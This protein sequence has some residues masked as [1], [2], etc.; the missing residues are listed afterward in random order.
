MAKRPTLQELQ[1][2]IKVLEARL[3]ERAPLDNAIVSPTDGS[4]TETILDALVEHVI[5]QD[6]DLKIQWANRAACES[7]GL[8]RKDLIGRYCYEIWPQRSE[9]CPDCPVLEAI[10]SGQPA[11]LEKQTPDGRT[12]LIQGQAVRNAAGTIIGGIETTLDITAQKAVETALRRSEERLQTITQNI[13]EVF[14]L[15][16]VKKQRVVYVSPAYEEIWGRTTARLLERYEEWQESIHPEDLAYAESSFASILE[17]GGGE[18][19]EYRIVR[20]D[21]SVRWVSDRGF[22]IR[23]PDGQISQ[24]TGFAEDI[25]DRKA[26]EATLQ[27]INYIISQ[28]PIVAFLWQNKPGWPVQFVTDNVSALLGYPASQFMSGKK[29]YRDVIHPADL[30]RVLREVQNFSAE[31]DRL[32]FAHQPYRIVTQQGEIRWVQDRTFIRRD[33]HGRI[34]HYQ[35]LVEDVTQRKTAEDALRASEANYRRLFSVGPDAIIL[36]D[37][38]TKQVIDANP[39]AVKQYGYTHA[40]L[41]GMKAL[42]LSAEPEASAAHISQVSTQLNQDAPSTLTHRLH[43][44]KD[45]TVFPVEIASGFYEHQGRRLICAILRDLSA[46]EAAEALVKETRLQVEAILN[47][48]PDLAW[49]KDAHSRFIA[50]NE[51]FG[52][53]CGLPADQLPGK[54]DLDIWPP[55]LAQRYRADDQDVLQSAQ[56]KRVEE[57]LVDSQGQT[58]WIETIKSPLFNPQGDVIGT[59]GIARDITDQKTARE[60]LQAEK[61]RLAVTLRSIGDAVIT[62]DR[63]GTITL[64]NPLAESLTGWTEQHAV[65]QPI[66]TVFHIINEFTRERCEDPVAKVIAGEQTVGLANNTL[67]VRRDG[68][69]IVIA[70]SGAPNRRNDGRIIG[71]VLVFRDITEQRRLQNELAKVQKI[72]SLGVEKG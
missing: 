26:M 5:Y 38:E 57:P 72:E 27:D 31:S 37:M 53:A 47:N 22:A 3:A 11:R 23:G 69:E 56:G 40:E 9:V 32:E 65:G 43:K 24:I 36:V 50:V 29:Q 61:E 14:W 66:R 17:T 44:K 20:P 39:A 6:R 49:L 55:D 25:T 16:D 33:V 51:A 70:D 18:P 41:C 68:T 48:I 7:A 15:F 54:T 12:W 63:H 35:G 64:L 2:Q 58:S 45:G 52:Q 10:K 42:D 46:R 19:R 60:A 59:V 67:L 71:V 30:E 34:T 4:Q 28:S 21:G 8:S 1:Q 62:T 13:R